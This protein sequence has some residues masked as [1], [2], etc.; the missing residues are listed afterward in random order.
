[1]C[2]IGFNFVNV[3]VSFFDLKPKIDEKPDVHLTSF[4]LLLL[5]TKRQCRYGTHDSPPNQ[6]AQLKRNF[7][8]IK[9]TES[10]I[11]MP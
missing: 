1:M 2:R 5:T 10:Q 11:Y 7:S 6:K 8:S 9:K 4:L 3:T